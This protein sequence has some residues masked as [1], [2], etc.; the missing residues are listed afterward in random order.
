MSEMGN[1]QP[2]PKVFF[3][4]KKNTMD[5]VQRLNGSGLYSLN[6]RYGLRYSPSILKGLPQIKSL[7]QNSRAVGQTY[8]I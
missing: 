7:E 2:S 3:Y 4:L 8:Y 6:K 5:A 1:P